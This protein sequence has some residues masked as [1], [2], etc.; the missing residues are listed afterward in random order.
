MLI[1]LIFLALSILSY[2][3]TLMKGM[4]YSDN[5]T[6]LVVSILTVYSVPL[7]I[8]LSTLFIDTSKFPP[9]V[10]KPLLYVCIG[11][12]ILWNLLLYGRIVYFLFSSDDNTTLL[13]NYLKTVAATSSFLVAGI[14]SYFFSKSGNA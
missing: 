11:V 1:F 6:D 13:M 9:S 10:D 8:I 14:L 4:I 5:F 3:I 2:F 7:A 12:V